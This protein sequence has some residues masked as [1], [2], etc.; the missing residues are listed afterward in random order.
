MLKTRYSL[1]DD[2]N[3][4]GKLSL[5]S[6]EER[7]PDIIKN[8]QQN[9]KLAYP[10]LH[11]LIIKWRDEK[12]KSKYWP[13]Y[14]ALFQSLFNE[15]ETD[16][17]IPNKH[18]DSPLTMIV[19][20]VND[21]GRLFGL[22]MMNERVNVAY[23][24]PRSDYTALEI[25][26]TRHPEDK[27]L[28]KSL[29]EKISLTPLI[30]ANLKAILDTAI[31]ESDAATIN[32]IFDF[33]LIPIPG[34]ID[35]QSTKFFPEE[36]WSESAQLWIRIVDNIE[37]ENKVLK[38]REKIPKA[39]LMA[40]GHSEAS[41]DPNYTKYS[42]ATFIYP[43]I[44]IY[45][46]DSGSVGLI[47]KTDPE[48]KIP[49]WYDGV[50]GEELTRDMPFIE[51]M[52]L[53]NGQQKGQLWNASV[54]D[55]ALH[56]YKLYEAEH[57]RIQAKR[58]SEPD[59]HGV[60]QRAPIEISAFPWNEGLFRYHK[61]QIVGIH[62]VS[63]DRDAVIKGLKL[64]N[65]LGCDCKFYYYHPEGRIQSLDEQALIEKFHIR[66]EEYQGSSAT[67]SRFFSVS[68]MEPPKLKSPRLK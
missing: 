6:L 52:E 60:L 34:D 4:Y 29:L 35:L 43:G 31:E 61:D 11:Q 49:Y 38:L 8:K 65:L 39:Q 37:E 24:N 44:P 40:G 53:N 3:H 7:V 47:I 2:E 14:K 57:Q 13:R 18:A 15:S 26:I 20:D 5:R 66:E 9:K 58:S 25:A 62:M 64:K 23:I 12:D 28:L 42:P 50:G 17:N 10:L 56:V 21:D 30:E 27:N 46:F 1:V 22:F 63:D 67:H 16:L 33:N 55:I 54:Y 32:A 19:S 41:N 36:L 45:T 68:E 59:N 51:G 48:D